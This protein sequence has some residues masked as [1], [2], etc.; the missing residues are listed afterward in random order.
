VLLGDKTSAWVLFPALFDLQWRTP[1]A[2][3]IHNLKERADLCALK[4]CSCFTLK[5]NL[6][7]SL[8]TCNT[9][10]SDN[11]I[12]FTHLM[13]AEACSTHFDPEEC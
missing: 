3:V 12:G 13:K 1:E 8:Y 5:S 6:C 2:P 11:R 10:D 7:N 9:G 4:F